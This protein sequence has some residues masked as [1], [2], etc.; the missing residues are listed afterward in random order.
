MPDTVASVT[1]RAAKL[2]RAHHD[3]VESKIYELSLPGI[4]Q[5]FF[6]AL[7]GAWETNQGVM[8]LTLPGKMSAGGIPVEMP[9]GQGVHITIA[10]HR[11]SR[12]WTHYAAVGQHPNLA[13][14]RAWVKKYG[15]AY[16]GPQIWSEPAVYAAFRQFVH[17]ENKQFQ[18]M[19]LIAK[20]GQEVLAAA[21]AA[22]VWESVQGYADPTQ[23]YEDAIKKRHAVFRVPTQ[24]AKRVAEQA[25]NQPRTAWP[26]VVP[27]SVIRGRGED[28]VM[29]TILDHLV[30]RLGMSMERAG[31]AVG[32]SK[33]AVN[34]YLRRQKG[35]DAGPPQFPGKPPRGVATPNGKENTKT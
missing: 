30:N 4:V 18:A 15:N 11:E 7:I 8:S 23:R 2:V 19:T 5:A 17:L 16:E 31:Q 24:R 13:A 25:R 35:L 3:M 32:L 21:Q 14:V 10:A 28:N 29:E 33:S 1:T 26:D 27:L 9:G 6:E 34:T 22:I 20:T 12:T